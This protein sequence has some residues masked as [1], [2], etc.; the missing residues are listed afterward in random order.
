MP[1]RF[2]ERHSGY[3]RQGIIKFLRANIPPGRRV[4]SYRVLG[5]VR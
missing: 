1:T 4:D 2:F 3:L 5:V